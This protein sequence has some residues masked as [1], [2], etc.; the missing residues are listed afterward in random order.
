MEWAAYVCGMWQ[1]K[2]GEEIKAVDLA[3][4]EDQSGTEGGCGDQFVVF[5]PKGLTPTEL[6]YGIDVW[7][8]KEA[9]STD[10]CI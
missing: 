8:L 2:E 5:W 1:I 7:F 10:I 6:E 4:K 3:G 9:R